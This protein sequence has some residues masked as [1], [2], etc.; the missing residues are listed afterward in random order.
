[1]D[2]DRI[3]TSINRGA[4][5]RGDSPRNESPANDK[6]SGSGPTA[7]ATAEVVDLSGAGLVGSRGRSE[8]PFDAARVAALKAAI[9]EGRY[10]IDERRLAA[11]ILA[12]EKLFV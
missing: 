9:A 2:I 7:A 11:N 8:A 5:D 6:T 10:P 4:I 3:A 12:I 1:M